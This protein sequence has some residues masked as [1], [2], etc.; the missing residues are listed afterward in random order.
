MIGPNDQKVKHLAGGSV[1][2][3]ATTKWIPGRKPMERHPR[4]T[5]GVNCGMLIDAGE[6]GIY[7]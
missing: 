5:Q 1:Q 2:R 6:G 3:V 7:S 4:M